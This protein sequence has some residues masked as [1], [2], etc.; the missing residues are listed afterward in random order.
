MRSLGLCV[1]LAG[2]STAD[3]VGLRTTSC[4][5]GPAQQFMLNFRHDVAGG[6]ADKS[7]DVRDMLTANGS[8]LPLWTCNGQDNQQWSTS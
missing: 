1:E 2:G 4:D 6:L 8:P 3:G 7:V 5:G